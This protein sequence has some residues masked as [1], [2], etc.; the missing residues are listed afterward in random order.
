[1][2]FHI[3]HILGVFINTFVL[4]NHV[5]LVVSLKACASN[6]TKN[7]HRP[8]ILKQEA[9]KVAPT[10]CL[11][12][13]FVAG[14]HFADYRACA[15]IHPRGRRGPPEIKRMVLV[16]VEKL[17][18]FLHVRALNAIRRRVASTVAAGCVG[19]IVREPDPKVDYHISGSKIACLSE[20]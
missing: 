8:A 19:R 16:A 13:Q 17:T 11:S 5:F 2:I 14:R 4:V 9:S 7:T 15:R 18:H 20:C 6:H 10:R 3:K 1:M 12:I